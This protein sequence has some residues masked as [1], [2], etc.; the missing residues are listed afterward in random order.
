MKKELFTILLL[1]FVVFISV[2]LISHSPNDPSVNHQA[3][4]S[5]NIQNLF[6]LVGAHLSGLLSG[7]FGLASL[8]IPL[9]IFL[10]ALWY[11]TQKSPRQIIM[12]VVGGT[13][14]LFSTAGILPIIRENVIVRGGE[15]S[16]GGLTG[17]AISSFLVEYASTP[18]SVIIL[19]F[20]IFSGVVITTGISASQ[21]LSVI[22]DFTFVFLRFVGLK[23]VEANNAVM[24][25]AGRIK[26]KGDRSGSGLNI[27]SWESLGRLTDFRI[28]FKLISWKK[29]A[30]Q[31]EAG[32]KEAEQSIS[33]L[34]VEQ[35]SSGL[36]VEQSC[37]GLTVQD[38]E[39]SVSVET[40]GTVSPD[41]DFS[42]LT[43]LTR[44]IN[45]FSS[46]KQGE[47][48]SKN[49]IQPSEN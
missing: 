21:F 29:E 15:I 38:V 22:R 17:S 23:A 47:E 45:S 43:A 37:S 42:P 48:P 24:T 27:L 9:F 20:F 1:F 4:S 18:G 7:L 32:E 40:S 25:V 34:T 41:A 12:T 2:S 26:D 44:R 6:G 49:R 28:D 5:D 33:G 16:S 30:T 11:L 8:W 31:K 3:F 14:L 19:L 10:C 46:K 39:G 35:S 36:T 13:V